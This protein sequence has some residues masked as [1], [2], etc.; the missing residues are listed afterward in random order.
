MIFVMEKMKG[1][2]MKPYRGVIAIKVDG[3]WKKINANKIV[4]NKK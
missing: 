2:E 4:I 3:E 1:Y